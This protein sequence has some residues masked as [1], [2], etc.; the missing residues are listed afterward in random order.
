LTDHPTALQPHLEALSTRVAALVRSRVWGAFVAALGVL[1]AALGQAQTTRSLFERLSWLAPFSDK[2][3]GPLPPRSAESVLAGGVL[4]ALGA[5][6]FLYGTSRVWTRPAHL[7]EPASSF[8]RVKGLWDFVAL[9][10]FCAGGLL[11]FGAIQALWTEPYQHRMTF[12]LMA[13]TALMAAPFWRLGTT[14]YSAKIRLSWGLAAEAALVA[15]IVVVFAGANTHDLTSWRYTAWGDEYGQFDYVRG[16]ARGAMFNPF[17]QELSGI[18]PVANGAT[19]ALSMK[20]FGMN[21]FGWMFHDVIVASAGLICFYLLVRELFSTRV[22]II[23]AAL[24]GSSHYLIAY[25]HRTSNS[26]P[27]LPETAALWLLA[28]GLRRGSAL[29]L[30]GS[31]IM[32]SIGFYVY[33]TGRITVVVIAVYVLTLGWRAIGRGTPIPLGLGFLTGFAPLWAV[34][35]WGVIDAML[36]QSTVSTQDSDSADR[37]ARLADNVV[38][39]IF[40]FNYNPSGF[41]YAFGSLLDPVTAV[42]YVL[43]MAIVLFSVRHP[44]Y[45]LVAVWWAIGL[46]VA[47]FSNPYDVTPI[48]RLHF[49]LPATVLMAALAFDRGLGA[50]T[51]ALPSR[52]RAPAASVAIA[53]LMVP[54]ALL[55]IHRFWYEMPEKFGFSIS[56]IAVRAAMSSDCKSAA[57]ATTVISKEPG[58]LLARIFDSYDLGR[59]ELYPLRY[60]DA[61]RLS[62][63]H[64]NGGFNLPAPRIQ[65]LPLY[66]YDSSLSA[67]FERILYRDPWRDG[68]VVLVPDDEAW[69]AL[70]DHIRS[71]YPGKA[72]RKVSDYSKR[73]DHYVLMFY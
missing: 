28:R 43:G 29:S 3:E 19:M 10:A 45:R 55:N 42:L 48:S 4:L 63:A 68:C 6:L 18:L 49:V 23:A 16:M 64:A 8:P 57:G 58:P 5:M 40:G 71:A 35:R 15:A 62:K 72:E 24:L 56:A 47:G 65:P 67:I 34:N 22:A 20:V 30:Y 59:R 1:I 36:S 7:L 17:K 66:P 2:L 37:L 69:P 27:L 39:S 13:A 21:R 33:F 61:N 9:A 14:A 11:Y 60:S 12:L 51:D 31:G 70:A 46:S 44:A 25:V 54:V 38:R 50:T 26:N 53:L 52:A 41:H 32:A 73:S